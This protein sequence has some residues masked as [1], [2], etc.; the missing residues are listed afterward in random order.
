VDSSQVARCP[1]CG[2]RED[3]TATLTVRLP[4]DARDRLAR[5]LDVVRRELGLGTDSEAAAECASRAAWTLNQA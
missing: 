5:D 4:P 3:A 2:C 1:R